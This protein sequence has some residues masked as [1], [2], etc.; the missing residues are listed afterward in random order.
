MKILLDMNISPKWIEPLNAA[1]FDTIHWSLVGPYDAPDSV[2]LEW[3]KQHAYVVFTHDLDFG[4]ILAATGAD[5]P[6]VVQLRDQD[7][8][9]RAAETF[10]KESLARFRKQLEAGALITLDRRRSRARVLPLD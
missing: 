1:G 8:D 4:A 5:A 3:A 7:L 6:S 10:V 9:P 2:L